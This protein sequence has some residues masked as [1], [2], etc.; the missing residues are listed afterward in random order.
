MLCAGAYVW[1]SLTL[2]LGSGGTLGSAAAANCCDQR[3]GCTLG[4][5]G[6]SNL[7]GGTILC[8]G[9]YI[10]GGVAGLWVGGCV[11][12]IGEWSSCPYV[13]YISCVITSLLV[14]SVGGG[15]DAVWLKIMWRCSNAWIDDYWRFG[16]IF[17]WGADA[18]FAAKA[19]MTSSGVDMGLVI[20]LCLKKLPDILGVRVSSTQ[21]LHQK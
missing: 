16:G 9:G 17:P 15:G 6:G 7:G 20:Y 2:V 13:S 8:I 1:F 12:G 19:M 21:N 3:R 18:R 11:S 5:G 10:L 4:G 14:V